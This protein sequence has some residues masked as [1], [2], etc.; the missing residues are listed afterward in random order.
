MWVDEQVCMSVSRACECVCV[1]VWVF[2]EHRTTNPRPPLALLTNIQSPT[3]WKIPHILKST[4]KVPQLHI[5][6]YTHICTNA[7]SVFCY[8]FVLLFVDYFFLFAFLY[9]CFLRVTI[10]FVILFYSKLKG[11]QR[12]INKELKTTFRNID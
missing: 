3:H 9:I 2:I 10:L 1:C 5:Y 7:N 8:I 12:L 6:T 4:E 11:Y